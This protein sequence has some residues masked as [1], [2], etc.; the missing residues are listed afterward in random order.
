MLRALV[1]G[2]GAF[3]MINVGIVGL[4]FMGSMHL[5]AYRHVPGV[6]I[7]AL[8]SPSGKRLDGDFSGVSG[9]VGDQ[10]PVKLDMTGVK[11]FRD[12][13]AFINDPDIHVVDI[14]APTA[15]HHSL[16]LAA[17]RAGKHVLCEKPLARSAKVA[18][19]IVT[20]AENAKGV[21]M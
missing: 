10:E 5:K 12:V 20:A 21:F 18:R 7:A 14:C 2:E 6:R 17:L 11:A 15:A 3:T 16:A 1:F 19:E 9:N 4:G 8:C 13:I